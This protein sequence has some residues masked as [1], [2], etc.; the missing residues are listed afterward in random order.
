MDIS[1]SAIKEKVVRVI[2]ATFKNMVQVS[3]NETIIPML[4]LKLLSV[5]EVL[6]VRK[7]S[8]PEIVEDMMVLRDVLGHHVAELSTWDEYKTEIERYARSILSIGFK[9]HSGSTII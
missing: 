5:V 8:D 2:M 7:W 3:P 4:G 1:K 9:L 6:S